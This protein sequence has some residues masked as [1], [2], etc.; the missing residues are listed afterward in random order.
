M[1]VKTT[2]DV[3]NQHTGIPATPGHYG[4]SDILGFTAPGVAFQLQVAFRGR[5]RQRWVPRADPTIESP[6]TCHRAHSTVRSPASQAARLG[7]MA[8]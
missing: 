3:S 2:F 4:T 5:C 6:S 7:M 8:V 1:G